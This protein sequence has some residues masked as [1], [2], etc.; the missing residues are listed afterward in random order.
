MPEISRIDSF[1][2][3]AAARAEFWAS[4]QATHAVLRGQPG[5]LGDALMEKQS[6]PGRFNAVTIVRW[7][8]AADL[9]GA[10]AAV[11]AAH[12][13]SGFDA[14]EFLARAGIE[15]ETGGNFVPVARAVGVSPAG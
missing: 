1:A 2:V 15:A 8:S 7:S 5:F 14:A 9:P 6:G 13:A 10:R 12:R 3:P 11:E 4:V